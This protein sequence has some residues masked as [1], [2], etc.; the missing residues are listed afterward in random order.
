MNNRDANYSFHRYWIIRVNFL[1]TILRKTSVWTIIISRLE[2]AWIFHSV[3]IRLDTKFEWS[4][5]SCQVEWI[6]RKGWVE[7]GRLVIPGEAKRGYSPPGADRTPVSML[8]SPLLVCFHEHFRRPGRGQ[9]PKIK[10][11]AAC[12]RRET[13]NVTPGFL[14]KITPSHRGNPATNW[15]MIPFRRIP[16]EIRE[17]EVAAARSNS[18]FLQ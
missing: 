17:L 10:F 6:K 18:P 12:G 16:G 7:N 8:E 14:V 15:K 13:T 4:T 2:E 3:E 1:K 11:P 9:R 5:R